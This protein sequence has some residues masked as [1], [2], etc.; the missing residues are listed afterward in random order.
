MIIEGQSGG[1]FIQIVPMKGK[2][3]QN[4]QFTKHEHSSRF[5]PK[6]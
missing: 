2:L 6:R 5:L 4:M 1:R 3:L